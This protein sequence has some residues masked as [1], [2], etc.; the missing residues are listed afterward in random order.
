MRK[1]TVRIPKFLIF[2]VAF[3]FIAIILKL[4][5]VS[6][7]SEVDGI[8]LHNLASSRNTKTETIYAKRGTIYDKEGEAL[9]SVVNSYKIIAYLDPK[10]EKD[11]VVDKEA[12]A[13][14]LNETLG[15]DYNEALER[16]NKKDKYQVEFGTKGNNITELLK[17]KIESYNLP[18]IDFIRSQKRTYSK[19][20]FASYIIGYAKKPT[21]E[22]DGKIIGELGLESY[23]NKE[24]SG[25]D[26]Y[27]TY[28]TDAYGYTLPSAEVITEDA[29]NGD[30]I[31]LTLD[32]DIQMFAETLTSNLA[33]NYTMD[34]L[35]FT[36]MDAKTG[37]I[38][39]SS[40]VPNFD[41]ND[42]EGLTIYMNPL[43]SYTYE[44]GST[45][46][47][48]S[49]ASAIEEGIY[50]GSELYHSGQI[51]VADAIIKDHNK[52]QGW[53]DISFD[54][55]Y[56]YSS[57][58][59]ATI[60]ARRLGVDKLTD[61]YKKLG[62]G[63][64]TGIEL[65]SEAEGVVN[66]HYETELANAGFGQGISVTPIQMLEALSA[67]T[68]DGTTLKPYIV[69]KI[70]D[71]SGK[72]IYKGERTEV[73]KVYSKE[74]MDYMKDLMYKV[75]YEGMSSSKVWQP[76][77]TTMLGKT[78]TAQIASKSGGYSDGYYDYVRSFAGIFPKEDP[79]YIV[80]VAAQRFGASSARPI[81]EELTKVVD[82]IVSYLGIENEDPIQ[83]SKVITL[84]NYISEEVSTTKDALAGDGIK[85]YTLG[86]GKYIINQ[87]PLK[88]EKV[89]E[90][91]KVFLVS[92]NH[93]YVM[94]DLT[95]WS[96][97]E[98]KTY[99]NILGI[100]VNPS[101]Y[102]Y[103]TSQNIPPGT[104]VTDDLVLEVTLST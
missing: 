27:S 48:F 24:L 53:G 41:P 80:Y 92:N 70:V 100:K 62:F 103:V 102:G 3:L 72:T 64:K 89:L 35:I 12:T 20:Q 97:N 42:R 10:R 6:L 43:V 14:M 46:K 52:G 38:V 9:A 11:Y 18:G 45:M 34:W 71:A 25:T 8:N 73:E 93:D 68:N 1:V 33:Q 81:A 88:N 61:Y 79:Q 21:G 101:G 28:Q 37:A 104:Q 98:V 77:K 19:G 13:K 74:T 2:I 67:L 47:T 36:V 75:V 17:S 56:T 51:K 60:I 29:V 23:Y 85:V 5:Y 58:V 69:D 49:F 76:T 50:N 32:S 90:G 96:L 39:A 87:Y 44:P 40:T 82:D 54:T 83:D 66:F 4:T 86:T 99:A 95:G 57:N 63:K 78:G 65:S 59:A 15:I 84:N 31:Y 22:E 94:E 91:S 55:G 7:S 30:D 26:G 16:L